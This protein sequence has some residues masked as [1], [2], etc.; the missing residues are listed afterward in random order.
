MRT[1][2]YRMT[3]EWGDCDPAGIVYFPNFFRYFD[4][5]TTW[6]F[7]EALGLK[8]A[9]WMALYGAAGLPMADIQA[10]FRAP[11]AFG[12]EVTVE[13]RITRI[14]GSSVSL[15]HRVFQGERLHV[16][17]RA[18]RVW[19]TRDGK[20]IHATAIPSSV[21]ERLLGQDPPEQD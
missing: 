10:S 7:T 21:R 6:L 15:E 18:V 20:S 1:S 3:V 14:G 13:T 12:D 5:A 8:K 9:E 16:E 11:A 19:V 2:I 4:N 17:A